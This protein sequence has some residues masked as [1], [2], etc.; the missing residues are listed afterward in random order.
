M[1]AVLSLW[2]AGGKTNG[3]RAEPS[4]ETGGKV[5]LILCAGVRHRQEAGEAVTSPE[6]AA[7]Q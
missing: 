1:A 3:R 4:A 7:D 2:E 5:Q 6:R